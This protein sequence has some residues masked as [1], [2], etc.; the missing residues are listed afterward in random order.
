MPK[1]AT[2]ERIAPGDSPRRS[3]RR[4]T[5]E[6]QVID[7]SAEPAADESNGHPA[8]EQESE[9]SIHA[10]TAEDAENTTSTCLT[11]RKH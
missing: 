8:A 10:V 3:K 1:K 2:S 11:W 6:E 9:A 4:R 5:A 7:A